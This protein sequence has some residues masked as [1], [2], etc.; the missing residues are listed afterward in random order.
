[1]QKWRK[2]FEIIDAFKWTGGPDQIEDPVWAVEAIKSGGIIFKNSGTPYVAMEVHRPTSVVAAY[3]G[4][5]VI[6]E[7]HGLLDICPKHVF[8]WFYKKVE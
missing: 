8:E 3:P 6:K 1:M 2:K 5:Y 7:E 4:D